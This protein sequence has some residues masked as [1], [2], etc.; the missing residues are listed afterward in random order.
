M[1]IKDGGK[2]LGSGKDS[3]RQLK[4]SAREPWSKTF[5]GLWKYPNE[6]RRNKKSEQMKEREKARLWGSCVGKSDEN[7]YSG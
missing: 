7:S 1:E 5:G 3:S 6:G 4:I 2:V